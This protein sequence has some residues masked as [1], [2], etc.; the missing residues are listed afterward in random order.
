MNSLLTDAEAY[1]ITGQRR[2]M[3]QDF[4]ALTQPDDPAVLAASG[5]LYVLA[6]G[7]GGEAHGEV[8]SQTAV[9]VILDHYYTTPGSDVGLR[10]LQLFEQANAAVYA[11]SQPQA[12][13][14][15]A[16]TLVA[17][18]LR[19]NRL[20]IAHVGDS[21][22]YLIRHG[23]VE[24]LTRDHSLLQ[25][26][27]DQGALSPDEINTFTRTNVLARSIGSEP[28]VQADVSEITV[29]PDD[30]IL[31]STDGL[32]QYFHEDQT[33]AP[34]CDP[35]KSARQIAHDLA[36]E[37]NAR[38][39]SDNI[40]V[41]VVK[42]RTPHSAPATP[43]SAAATTPPAYDPYGV[44]APLRW[45][46]PNNPPDEADT[47]PRLA[48][49]PTP[50]PF[51]PNLPLNPAPRRPR[52]TGWRMVALTGMLAGALALIMVSSTLINNRLRPTP[53]AEITTATCAWQVQGNDTLDFITAAS[54]G[55]PTDPASLNTRRTTILA[56]NPYATQSL[57]AGMVLIVPWSDPAH[58]FDPTV[59]PKHGIDGVQY[60]DCR[61]FLR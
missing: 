32:H 41:V 31:L 10:L 51:V 26:L 54:L 21:R 42:L 40:S 24:R 15:T 1:S 2:T 49:E 60:P 30:I 3:N 43:P 37:A 18:V 14:R 58:P 38:G 13:R 56:R 12:Q 28:E 36:N 46:Y 39:G 4:V 52:Q 61:D 55:G 23:I 20:T 53:P 6:D 17:A 48:V 34:F 27:L 35:S 59:P 11:L 44:T 5:R 19:N 47:A 57:S 29:E 22:A 7:V 16:T 50:R 25:T 45:P 9:Q 8:A 33:L